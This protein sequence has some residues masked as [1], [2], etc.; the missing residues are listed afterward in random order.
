[1]ARARTTMRMETSTRA[2]GRGAPGMVWARTFTRTE[3][4]T[5]K[6]SGRIAKSMGLARTSTWM[7][8]SAMKAIRRMAKE[9]VKAYPTMPT[10]IR[11]T[12]ASGRVT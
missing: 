12:R 6:A 7:E 2:N 4:S 9:V 11:S 10:A 5:M 8:T 1:M 3:T